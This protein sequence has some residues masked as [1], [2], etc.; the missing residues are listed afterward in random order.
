MASDSTFKRLV[1]KLISLHLK[2]KSWRKIAALPEFEGIPPGTLCSISK[3]DYEPKDN[4][5]RKRLGLPIIIMQYKDP[6][7]GRFMEKSK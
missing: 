1:D 4:E 7:T 2:Y 6:V 3:G 5:I